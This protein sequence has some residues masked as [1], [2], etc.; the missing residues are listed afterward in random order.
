MWAGG[1]GAQAA[2]HVVES[3]KAVRKDKLGN[4]HPGPFKAVGKCVRVWAN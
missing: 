1:P 4:N 2:Q 3:L